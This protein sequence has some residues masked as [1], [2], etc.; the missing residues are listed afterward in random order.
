[1]EAFWPCAAFYEK[2]PSRATL[3][4]LRHVSMVTGRRQTGAHDGAA[5]QV[6]GNVRP[7]RAA[8]VD[9]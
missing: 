9:V 3:D 7:A 8:N 1:M 6:Q 2:E 5:A 4:S